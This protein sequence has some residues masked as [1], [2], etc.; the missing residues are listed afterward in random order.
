NLWIGISITGLIIACISII[1]LGKYH[2]NKQA[3]KDANIRQL[4]R[5]QQLQEFRSIL[6]AEEKERNRIARDLHDSIMVQ[7]SVVKMNLSALAG[8]SDDYIDKKELLPHIEQ[9]NIAT[10]SLR[11]VA[12]HLMPDML[13]EGGLAEAL[14][15]FCKSLQPTLPFK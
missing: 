10:Q 13:L 1:L 6:K 5:L 14:Q 8:K 3:L 15:Y 11:N 4:L 9:L 12:H 7:F 2:R